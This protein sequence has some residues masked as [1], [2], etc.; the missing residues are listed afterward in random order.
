M[1]E[2]VVEIV[3]RAAH[4]M[5]NRNFDVESK[6][7]V[8]NNVTTADLAVQKYLKSQLVPLI[9]GC[10]FVGE[11]NGFDEISN[12]N[13]YQWIVD[14]IDGTANFIRD[15]G[16]SA[17]SVGLVK[18]GR[19]VLGV[20]YNPNRDEMFCAEEGNGAYLN[21]NPIKV[22]IGMDITMYAKAAGFFA[23]YVLGFLLAKVVVRYRIYKEVYWITCRTISQLHAFKQE[24]ITKD[25]V[26]HIFYMTLKKNMPS[27]V[28]M[29]KRKKGKEKVNMRKTYLKNRNSAETILFEVMVLLVSFVLWV[30]VFIAIPDLKYSIAAATVLTI[31]NIICGCI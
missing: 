12:T 21:H 11:E 22:I 24:G 14:P 29:S 23:L 17:I 5:Q 18:D 20:V 6:G 8:S 15:M 9:G 2:K 25:L 28:V 13:Q 30:G 4:L 19:P 31:I 27:V 1:I 26:Q 16:L 7:T 3:R 10:V